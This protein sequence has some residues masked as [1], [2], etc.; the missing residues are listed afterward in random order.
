M[1]SMVDRRDFMQRYSE[2]IKGRITLELLY[3]PGVVSKSY[4]Q[5]GEKTL[6]AALDLVRLVNALKQ[7]QF[8]PRDFVANFNRSLFTEGQLISALMN[9]AIRRMDAF[10]E[11]LIGLPPNQRA[12]RIRDIDKIMS[13]SLQVVEINVNDPALLQ[14]LL[15]KVRNTDTAGFISS[16]FYSHCVCVL[17]AKFVLFCCFVSL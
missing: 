5:L 3:L 13:D 15:L 6:C 10:F 9:I 4:E 8:L 1:L 7:Y 2:I 11:A 16:T 17:Y 12:N 14:T